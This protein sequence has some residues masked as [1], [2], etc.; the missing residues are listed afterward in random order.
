MSKNS[1]ERFSNRVENYV[2]YRPDYPG[3]ILDFLQEEAG[4]TS[5]SVVA[6]IG[7]GTGISARLFLENGNTVYGIEP[8][9]DMREAAEKFL[10]DFPNFKST[11]G[12]AENTMLENNSV[13]FVIAAQ[14]FHWFKNRETAGEFERVLKNEGFIILIW[15]ERQLDSNAFLR[16][17]ENLLKK[18]G[19]DYEKVRHDNVNRE[20][21]ADFFQIQ[22]FS[23]T[24]ENAQTLDYKGMKGRILSSSYM[25]SEEDEDFAELEKKLKPLFA[26]YEE[27]GKIRILYDTK[28]FCGK[29]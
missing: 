20:N 26:D 5:S 4:F 25:P 22:F 10:A 9:E 29:A 18:F 7:S 28:V 6:D 19:K 1:V 8:N 3:E 24:F 2:K 15:N 17:Y 11:A 12:T 23:K 13:D 16:E 14:A 21:L 27:N